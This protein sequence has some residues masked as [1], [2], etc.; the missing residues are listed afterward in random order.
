MKVGAAAARVGA[1][2]EGEQKQAYWHRGLQKVVHLFPSQA[3]KAPGFGSVLKP[4]PDPQDA[5]ATRDFYA[6]ALTPLGHAV[7]TSV[8]NGEDGEESAAAALQGAQ[9]Q[10]GSFDR[11]RTPVDIAKEPMPEG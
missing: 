9:G 4:L 3:A 8:A 7:A 6:V 5:E 10:G 1:P 2:L 11:P